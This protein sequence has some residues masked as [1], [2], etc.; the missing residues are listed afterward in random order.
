MRRLQKIEHIV[1]RILEL[2]EDA[3]KSDDILYLYTC[4][5]FYRGAMNMSI[6]VFF[7]SRD[8]LGIPTYESVSRVRR[9]IFG[10]RPELKPKEVTKLREE[11]E[12]VY[13]DYATN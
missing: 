3:R 9:K 1:E 6:K 5:Y 7:N 13:R 12:D 4:E 10:E 11:M 8:S 2:K